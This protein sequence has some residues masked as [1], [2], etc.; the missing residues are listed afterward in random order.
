MNCDECHEPMDQYYEFDLCE[1]CAKW[2]EDHSKYLSLMKKKLRPSKD[3]DK[4]IKRLAEDL[5]YTYERVAKEEGWKTQEDCRTTFDEL[6]E[7]NKKVM[8]RMGELVYFRMEE[9]RSRMANE[10]FENFQRSRNL[11]LDTRIET[12]IK[13][14]LKNARRKG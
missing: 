10:A 13:F 12:L 5:H 7:K 14:L 11:D 8:L 2:K 6:P 1:K 4:T 9:A 3:K